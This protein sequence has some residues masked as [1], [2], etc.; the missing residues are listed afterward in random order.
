MLTYKE[1]KSY[2]KKDIRLFHSIKKDPKTPKISKVL[3]NL[4]III[5]FLP[6]PIDNILL[7]PLLLYLAVKFLPYSLYKKHHDKIFGKKVSYP[8]SLKKRSS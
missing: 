4:A 3:I 6:G 5:S 1:V 8:I 2:L 7:T